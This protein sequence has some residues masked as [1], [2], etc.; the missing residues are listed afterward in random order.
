MDIGE[1][2]LKLKA[3]RERLDVAIRALSALDKAR[4][5]K[6]MLAS[7]KKRQ[8]AAPRLPGKLRAR[9]PSPG[10]QGGE[11]AQVIPIRKF[12]S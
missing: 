12:G 7:A 2:L 11:S 4:S 5:K 3:E 8:P 9:T 10:P 1:I 6:A